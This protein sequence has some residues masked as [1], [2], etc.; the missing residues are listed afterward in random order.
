MQK[1][2]CLISVASTQSFP[3]TKC[4]GTQSCVENF[5]NELYSQKEDFFVITPK[6]TTFKDYPYEII[7][8]ESIGD[9]QRFISEVV[10]VCEEKK[11]DIFFVNGFW[12]VQPLIKFGKPIICTVHCGI[13]LRED[14]KLVKNDLVYYRFISKDQYNRWTK[15]DWDKEHNFFYYTGINEDQFE[16]QSKNK[17]KN[18]YFL[19]VSSL[20]WPENTKG[21]YD[22]IK[23]A[24]L[25]PDKKFLAYGSGDEKRERKLKMLSFDTPNFGFMGHLTEERKKEV[26]LNAKA[27]LFLSHLREALNRV[28]LESLSVG[29]PVLSYEIPSVLEQINEPICGKSSGDLYGVSD[30]LHLSFGRDEIAKKTYSKFSTEKEYEELFSFL[31]KVKIY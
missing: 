4:G 2:I 10:R 8:T 1:K 20:T 16:F 19:W 7:E 18:S 25:N 13:I 31:K 26:F 14:S 21:I 28:V 3:N 15:T 22:F 6:R 12:A 5:A 17:S 23:I 29:T 9:N 11:V 30:N 27:T 24:E